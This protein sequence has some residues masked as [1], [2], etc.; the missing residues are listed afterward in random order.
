MLPIWVLSMRLASQTQSY[1]CLSSPGKSCK[2]SQLLQIKDICPW[3][4]TF[5][6]LDCKIFAVLIFVLPS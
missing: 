6:D 5:L 4:I 2:Y 3:L 1:F